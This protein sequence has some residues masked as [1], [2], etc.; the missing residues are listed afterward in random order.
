MIK[1]FQPLKLLWLFQYQSIFSIYDN[2]CNIDRTNNL[3]ESSIKKYENILNDMTEKKKQI[4]SAL[5]Y[6]EKFTTL[7]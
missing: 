5:K 1:H 7:S 6:H 2:Y 4:E 3:F